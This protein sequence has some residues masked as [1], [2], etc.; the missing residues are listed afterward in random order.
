MLCLVVCE[1]CGAV[2]NGY[3]TGEPDFAKYLSL[4]LEEAD[5]EWE[6]FAAER[7]AEHVCEAA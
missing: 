1:S 5:R 4:S 7:R 6:R 2:L 3:A